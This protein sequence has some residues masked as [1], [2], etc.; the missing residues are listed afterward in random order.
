MFIDYLIKLIFI[1]IQITSI[2]PKKEIK[3]F[4]IKVLNKSDNLIY[5]LA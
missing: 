4:I 2:I 5:E 3:Y 1:F